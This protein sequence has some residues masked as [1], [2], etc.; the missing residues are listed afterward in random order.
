MTS[1]RGAWT[2]NMAPK[3]DRHATRMFGSEITQFI[4]PLCLVTWIMIQYGTSVVDVRFELLDDSAEK[5]WS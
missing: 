4:D 2:V 5:T 1:R 3:H